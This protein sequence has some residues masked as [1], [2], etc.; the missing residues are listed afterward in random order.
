MS[1]KS[2]SQSDIISK[3]EYF[4]LYLDNAEENCCCDCEETHYEG[5]GYDEPRYK[6]CFYDGESENCPYIKQWL[7]DKY[8]EYV[9]EEENK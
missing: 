7:E 3:E 4:K 2:K 6:T 5:D 1:E 8:D 9:F